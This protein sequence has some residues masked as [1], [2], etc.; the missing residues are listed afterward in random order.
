MMLAWIRGLSSTITLGA[1]AV[2]GAVIVFSALRLWDVAVDDPA[3]RRE[4]LAGYVRQAEYEAEKAKAEEA[5]RQR[6]AAVR[7][8]KSYADLLA[9]VRGREATAREQLEQR[10]A[11]YER[12]LSDNGRSCRLTQRD[13]EWLRK[14]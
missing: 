7:A 3:V 6:D 8:A 4:A 9:D 1:G 10:I 14:P 11:D 13:I 5:A 2:A 12:E